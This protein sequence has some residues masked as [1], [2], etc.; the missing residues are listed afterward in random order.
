MSS[1]I[2]TATLPTEN[3]AFSRAQTG[4]IFREDKNETVGSFEAGFYEVSGVTI[5]S[6]KRFVVLCTGLSL[7]KVFRASIIVFICSSPELSCYLFCGD[8]VQ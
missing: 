5:E 8:F 7:S 3:I 4:W 1:D 6:R 2:I